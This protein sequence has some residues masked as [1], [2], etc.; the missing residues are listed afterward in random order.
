MVQ[1]ATEAWLVGPAGT[2][3]HIT[4]QADG[5]WYNDDGTVIALQDT[6]ASVD[7]VN[8]CGVAPFNLSPDNPLTKDCSVHDYMYS[9]PAYQRFNTEQEANEYLETLIENDKDAGLWRLCAK[10]FYWIT[11][12]L[13]GFFWENDATRN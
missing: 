11:Q 3:M 8:E 1:M 6:S 4:Q 13:G 10:P 9:S 7:P 5:L 12:L 2:K